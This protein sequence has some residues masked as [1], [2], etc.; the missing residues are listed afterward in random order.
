MSQTYCQNIMEEM[1]A[2]A[3]PLQSVAPARFDGDVWIYMVK[4][5]T[6]DEA[7]LMEADLME[8]AVTVDR[9]DDPES[10]LPKEDEMQ[11]YRLVRWVRGAETGTSA[12]DLGGLPEPKPMESVI[13]EPL[14][15]EG[16]GEQQA[17]QPLI[18]EEVQPF[19][20][21]GQRQP[22]PFGEGGQ[23]QP[24]GGSV[25]RDMRPEDMPPELW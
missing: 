14:I 4:V 20:E 24:P 22:Q 6:V 10:P 12:Q 17:P 23:R 9:L 11:G 21:G 7:D 5:E 15:D 25:E 8:V 18:D 3:R 19:G 16:F 1:L 2:G 13:P